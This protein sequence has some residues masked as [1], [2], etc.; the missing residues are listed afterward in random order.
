VRIDFGVLARMP[1]AALGNGPPLVVL[2]GLSPSTGFAGTAA[3]RLALGPLARLATSHRLVVFNRR[4]GLPAGMSMAEMAAEHRDAIRAGFDS[5][6][7]D[8]V[9]SSTGGSIAQQLAADHPD[10]VRRLVL[11]S[12]ACRLGPYGRMVQSAA[13]AEI[14]RGSH[15]RALATLAAGLVPAGHGRRLV[16]AATFAVPPSW[17]TGGQN[18][19]DLATTIEAEDAFD[20]TR[21]GP[22]QAPTLLLA[23]RDDRF[24]SLALFHETAQLVPHCRLRVFDG[25]G[26]VTVARDPDFGAEIGTFVA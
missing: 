13:A 23:G 20:L 10:A 16:A 8:L 24:Y 1:Y 19:N 7:V 22:I 6:P 18:L 12:T 26:H 3:V 9:G 15:R 5:H 21:C 4:A 25:R 2:T 11:V 17:L 14:R